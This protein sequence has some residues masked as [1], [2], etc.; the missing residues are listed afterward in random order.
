M[1]DTVI[2][3]GLTN[4][5]FRSIPP[6]L[7]K[8]AVQQAEDQWTWIEDTLRHSTADWL[9]VAGHYPGNQH[10][11]L[12]PISILT[13]VNLGGTILLYFLYDKTSFKQLPIL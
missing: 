12:V 8:E 4:P 5:V 1:I 11:S 3:A 10:Y 13:C 9:I 7:A 2:L 6:V